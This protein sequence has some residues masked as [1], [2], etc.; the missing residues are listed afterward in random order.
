MKNKQL[1]Y[2]LGLLFLI[3]C[4]LLIYYNSPA[5][6]RSQLPAKYKNYPALSD[7][8][9]SSHHE[10]KQ[11][12]SGPPLFIFYHY[13]MRLVVISRIEEIPTTGDDYLWDETYY[14]L[15]ENGKL[16][17]SLRSR[18]IGDAR[19]HWFGGHLLHE[20]YYTDYPTTG[21]NQPI[22]Y[23]ERNKDLSMPMEA[24]LALLD[25]LGVRAE[26]ADRSY[27]NTT[28]TSYFYAVNNQVHRVY[29]PKD[30]ITIDRKHS[31]VFVPYPAIAD[32]LPLTGSYAMQN[33]NA[34]MQVDY[35]LKQSYN[36]TNYPPFLIPDPVTR[37]S[38]WE[39][40]GYY[41]IRY[42]DDTLCFKYPLN[43]YPDDTLGK[44]PKPHYANSMSVPYYMTNQSE[45]LD[46]FCSP[47]LSFQ[48]LTIGYATFEH[49]ATDG[50]YIVV[51]K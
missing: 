40:T 13:L 36:G 7:N 42:P 32:E 47:Q 37:P 16:L 2:S 44:Y 14:R 46:F 28:P 48:L 18:D 27:F 41:S 43:Y 20:N 15:D 12:F 51:K 6:F 11:L 39:G 5:Y 1:Y 25:S 17:D 26:E 34:L 31:R 33:P 49:H 50:C 29:V 24:L 21:N 8:V 23:V 22:S 9:S 19:G 45:K 38:R 30:T 3:T 35:F 4:Y 10:V